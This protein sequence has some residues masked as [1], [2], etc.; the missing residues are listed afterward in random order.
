MAFL[1]ALKVA[2][3]NAATSSSEEATLSSFMERSV[4]VADD[5][6]PGLYPGSPCTRRVLAAGR[7]SGSSCQLHPIQSAMNSSWIETWPLLLK[8]FR[9]NRIKNTNDYQEVHCLSFNVVLKGNVAPLSCDFNW[10]RQVVEHAGKPL[11]LH[12]ICPG[13]QYFRRKRLKTFQNEPQMD[14]TWA[15]RCVQLLMF[16]KLCCQIGTCL[17]VTCLE[18]LPIRENKAP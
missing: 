8:A 6:F 3:I 10:D 2:S 16:A 9:K 14:P 1:L 12:I 11:I 5:S 17:Q 18:G 4:A 15:Y 7:P 13:T